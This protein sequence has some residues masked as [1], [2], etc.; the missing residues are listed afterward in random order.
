MEMAKNT[1]I[2]V[3]R[4]EPVLKAARERGHLSDL[5][6]LPDVMS[7]AHNGSGN[8]IVVRDISALRSPAFHAGLRASNVRGVVVAGAWLRDLPRGRAKGL[9][10]GRRTCEG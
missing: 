3:R 2:A 10:D 8:G 7:L 6:I 9:R 5:V 1:V 4:R